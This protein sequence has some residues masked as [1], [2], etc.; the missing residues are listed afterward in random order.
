MAFIGD[1][2]GLLESCNHYDQKSGGVNKKNF[3][4][5]KAWIFHCK[6]L[7]PPP[8][9][10]NPSKLILEGFPD[11]I[12]RDDHQLASMCETLVIPA[13]PQCCENPGWPADQAVSVGRRGETV[14]SSSFCFVCLAFFLIF[15]NVLLSAIV[16][17]IFCIFLHRQGATFWLSQYYSDNIPQ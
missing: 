2:L 9:P 8:T 3:C 16:N 6:T 12:A 7:P 11:L 4:S 10:P 5:F 13:W 17:Y 15:G 1:M 14:T